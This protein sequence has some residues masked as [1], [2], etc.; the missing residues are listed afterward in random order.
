VDELGVALS[1]S[2]GTQ[3]C[4]WCA[5]QALQADLESR[6]R[7]ILGGSRAALGLQTP[8]F[9]FQGI[10]TSEEAMSRQI[11]VVLLLCTL[12][13]G[14]AGMADATSRLAGIGVI[15]EEKSTFDGATIV[16][17]SPAFLYREGAWLGVP[18][19]LGARWSSKAPEHV[20]MVLSYSSNI[21][22]GGAA[23]LGFS[24]LDIN[25]DGDI[26]EY[27]AA[28]LTSHDSSGYNTVSRTIYTESQNSVVIPLA[29]LQKML[30]AKDCRLRIQTGKGY[31]D[32]QFSIERIP[33]GQSTAILHLREFV[34][35]VQT[36]P[37]QGAKQ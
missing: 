17:M 8:I 27:K 15:D 31:E 14:C 18:I 21:S 30:L 16:K 7:G 19:K 23:Y 25:I 11:G 9:K 13:S 36:V 35:R 32:V 34:S 37:I 10:K 24:G 33:G 28:G 22:S 4:A 20:A 6:W 26:K 5:Q 2:S 12:V 3:N 1:A 29:T